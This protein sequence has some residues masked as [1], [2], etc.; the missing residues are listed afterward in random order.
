M[1]SHP[2]HPK[3]SFLQASP[4][5]K[6]TTKAKGSTDTS[7]ATCIGS[8]SGCRSVQHQ[9]EVTESAASCTAPSN[10]APLGIIRHS[11]RQARS[12]VCAASTCSRA[13][14]L[15]LSS[16]SAP[17]S[18]ALSPIRRPRQPGGRL[19]CPGRPAAQA[20]TP[21]GCPTSP[22]LP[23]CQPSCVETYKRKQFDTETFAVLCQPISPHE[24]L[25]VYARRVTAKFGSKTELC[26]RQAQHCCSHVSL[27]TSSSC[28]STWTRG[29]HS[30]TMEM[31]NIFPPPPLSHEP[32][33]PCPCGICGAQTISMLLADCSNRAA[34]HSCP[35]DHR[36]HC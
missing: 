7:K 13:L 33:V 35:A 9:E 28:R 18:S 15:C 36:W 5:D 17:R 14:L 24:I 11:R 26:W 31:L 30:P 10:A 32:R 4:H 22:S 25:K 21:I 34:K 27:Q 6:Q 8:G 19:W 16:P 12:T 2:G 20:F 29:H 23:L 3:N 1:S